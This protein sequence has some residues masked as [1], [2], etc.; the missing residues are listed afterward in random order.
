MNSFSAKIDILVVSAHPDDA[1][2]AMGGT[3]VALTSSGL[4]VHHLVLTR[5]EMSTY[6]DVETRMEELRAASEIVGC[7]YEVLDFG[8][9]RIENTPDNRL[10]VAERIRRLQ[11]KIVFAPY[12]TNTAAELG[13]IANIDHYTSGSLVRD[14]VK[15]A[16]LEKA[17][18]GVAKHTVKKLYFYMLPRHIRPT[19]AVD[20]TEHWERAFMAIRA[21]RSQM[22]IVH[23]GH[24][25][26]EHL[27]AMRTGL[28]LEIGVRYA[29]GFVTDQRLNFRPEHFLQV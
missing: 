4:K 14:A 7:S 12:H 15:L 28:G 19:I 9:L 8:D 22:D 3:L 2:M 26:E 6:G 17:V 24:Q 11:P 16:R 10:V 21:Y 20:V 29:E 18:P 1:E 23:L 27:L 13:G 25:I 5:G